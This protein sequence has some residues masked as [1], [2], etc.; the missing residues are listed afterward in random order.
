MNSTTIAEF[1]SG[2]PGAVLLTA[3]VF[4]FLVGVHVSGRGDAMT[5]TFAA[6]FGGALLTSLNTAR[7][8]GTTAEP[9]AKPN[10][11]AGGNR[12]GVTDA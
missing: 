1:L 12:A 2:R 10:G 7:T 6:G 3:V 8:Q 11:E 9:D 4:M 5:D